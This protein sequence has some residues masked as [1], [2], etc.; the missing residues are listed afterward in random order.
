MAWPF[1]LVI[2]DALFYLV[3][4]RNVVA[5]NGLTFSQVMPTNGFQPLW[6]IAVT[7]IIWLTDVAGVTSPSAQLRVVVAL[8][9]VLLAIGMLIVDR[10]LSELGVQP[11]GRFVALL[12]ILAFLGGPG[13]TLATEASLVLVTASAALVAARRLV[14]A[15]AGLPVATTI[16]TGVLLGLLVLSRLDTVFLALTVVVAIVMPGRHRPLPTRLGEAAITGVVAGAIVMPY[17]AWNVATY[18]RIMPIAGA[19]KVDP[20]QLTLLPEAV[21][22]TGFALLGVTST[23]AWMAF[24]GR[25]RSPARSWWLVTFIGASLAS[26]FYY[27]FA[28]LA[29]TGGG[30]YQVPLLLAAALASAPAIDRFLA[31][32][33][34][35][36]RPV[37][38]SALATFVALIALVETRFYLTGLYRVET[39]A[40]VRFGDDLRDVVGPNEVVAVNDFPGVLALTGNRPTI[41]FDGLTGDFAYQEN[42][43]DLGPSCTFARLGVQY[44]VA[45]ADGVPEPGPGDRT[46]STVAM[47][48]RLYEEGWSRLE[49]DTDELVLAAP[50]AGLQLFRYQPGCQDEHP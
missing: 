3:I 48:P 24:H 9:W 39:E 23:A 17:L 7:G 14:A 4:G 44:I 36:V 31:S 27:C 11:T 40:V 22:V 25:P 37:L 49:L 6:Q 42:L 12:G 13:F 8:S 16:A 33:R 20:S 32:P 28:S 10:L 21:G 29:W 2:D 15:E 43:R 5:G 46:R 18:D 26:L 1:L 50:G 38:A 34:R 41:A 35:Y 30:W 19:I 45:R 47:G